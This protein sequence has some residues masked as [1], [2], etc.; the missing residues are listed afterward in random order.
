[1]GF[2]T[3]FFATRN[4]VPYSL[5]IFKCEIIKNNKI[6]NTLSKKILLNQKKINRL[7][8]FL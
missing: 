1:M 4:Y 7:K 8:E 5:Q 6:R 3:F 2:V